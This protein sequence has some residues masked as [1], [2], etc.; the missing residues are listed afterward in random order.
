MT[1]VPDG[2]DIL[3]AVNITIETWYDEGDTYDYTLEKPNPSTGEFTAIIWKDTKKIG[4]GVATR[5][6]NG[7]IYIV[8]QFDPP[9]NVPGK[10]VQNVLPSGGKEFM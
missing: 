6:D 5:K 2:T 9:G 7:K 3:I 4:V 10:Y 1:E 8:I